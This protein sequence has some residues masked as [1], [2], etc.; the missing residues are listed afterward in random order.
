MLCGVDLRVIHALVQM[1]QVGAVEQYLKL[2]KRP[3]F[4]GVALGACYWDRR[5]SLA[6]ASLPLLANYLDDEVRSG[7]LAYHLLCELS[8]SDLVSPDAGLSLCVHGDTPT[9]AL[10]RLDR[11]AHT[12]N[13]SL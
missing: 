13:F 7:A 1:G 2:Y 3:R 8:S 6:P 9:G 4:G 11:I 12:L 5:R 10:S